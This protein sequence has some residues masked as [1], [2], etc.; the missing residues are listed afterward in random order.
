MASAKKGWNEIRDDI[1]LNDCEVIK[2]EDKLSPKFCH[3][4]KGSGILI[5]YG[6]DLKKPC[7]ICKGQGFIKS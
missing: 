4:C 2:K 1:L 5:E 7:P 3:E 6:V